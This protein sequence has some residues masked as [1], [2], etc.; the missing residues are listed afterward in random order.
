MKSKKMTEQPKPPFFH[1]SIEPGG[2]GGEQR[3]MLSRPPT[4]LRD[5]LH[6]IEG[7]TKADELMHTWGDVAAE[8]TALVVADRPDPAAALAARY[9]ES[10]GVTAGEVLRAGEAAVQR[11]QA[12]DAALKAHDGAGRILAADRSRIV[13]EGIQVVAD[14][15]TAR[16]RS[17]IDDL[18][19]AGIGSDDVDAK[20]AVDAHREDE[21]RQLTEAV[22]AYDDVRRSAAAFLNSHGRVGGDMSF[23]TCALLANVLD[24]DPLWGVRAAGMSAQNKATGEWVRAG[25]LLVPDLAAADH[26]GQLAWFVEHPEAVVRVATAR[27]FDT[28]HGE[29]TRARSAAITAAS[30]SK[31]IR[32]V[33]GENFLGERN[34]Q[35]VDGEPRFLVL[36]EFAKDAK[37]A[38]VW[39][40]VKPSSAYA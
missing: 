32:F 2:P 38:D 28:V 5:A 9:T 35:I 37:G 1:S 17:I 8:L 33:R 23:W 40:V 16:F 7:F 15:L 6:E 12:T 26:A 10:D 29:L 25:E 21:H 19:A 24:V 11:D 22:E 27:E 36:D 31:L 39:Q 14:S 34:G 4:A 30:P 13:A 20:A 3:P 18:R